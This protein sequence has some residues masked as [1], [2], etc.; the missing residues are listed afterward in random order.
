MPILLKKGQIG[1][2]CYLSV[3]CLLSN[4]DETKEEFIEVCINVD[5]KDIKYNECEVTL[6]YGKKGLFN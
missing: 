1:W 2:R 4:P 5:L 6:L 3:I